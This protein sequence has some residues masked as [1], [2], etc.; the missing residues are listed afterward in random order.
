MHMRIF[1]MI[2]MLNC[3][4]VAFA[5]GVEGQ[6]EEGISHGLARVVAIFVGAG[7]AFCQI[8]GRVQ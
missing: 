2:L 4:P 6:A 5:R 8:A 3:H 7:M 1:L